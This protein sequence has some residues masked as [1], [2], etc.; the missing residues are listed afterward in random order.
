HLGRLGTD[1]IALCFGSSSFFGG[2]SFDTEF[3]AEAA[4]HSHD[5]PVYTAA[6]AMTAALKAAGVRRPLVMM[7][8]WFTPPTFEATEK[9]LTAVG[10]ER[11]RIAQFDLGPQWAA[12]PRYNAFDEGARWAVDPHDVH[13]QTLTAFK[14]AEDTAV[15][16]ILVPGSGFRT[17]DA[18][19]PLEQELQIPVIT[20]NQSVLWYGLNQATPKP[21]TDTGHHPHGSLFTLPLPTNKPQ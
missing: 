9:Y 19:V 17:Q 2:P 13:R 11:I 14:D 10:I 6:M 15:D 18:V 4:S 20:A 16:G 7:P 8:P 5:T 12:I 1:S 3:V 21:R